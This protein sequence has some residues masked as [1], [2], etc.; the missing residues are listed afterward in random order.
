MSALCD[1]ASPLRAT[2]LD[3]AGPQDGQQVLGWTFG[4]VETIYSLLS[5]TNLLRLDLFLELCT[6]SARQSEVIEVLTTERPPAT[7]RRPLQVPC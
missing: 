5:L 6:Y 7:Y 4:I 2:P 1:I 3:D